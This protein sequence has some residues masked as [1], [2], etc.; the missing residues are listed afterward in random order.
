[1]ASLDGGRTAGGLSSRCKA[2]VASAARG[3]WKRFGRRLRS[4]DAP[5]WLRIS[6]PCQG[7]VLGWASP[8]LPWEESGGDSGCLLPSGSWAGFC[9]CCKRPLSL[10]LDDSGPQA[11]RPRHASQEPERSSTEQ[12]SAG[13]FAYVVCIWGQ[14]P[15]YILGAMVLAHSLRS[16]GTGHDLVALHTNDVPQEAVQLLGRSGWTTTEVEYVEAC[17]NLYQ[18]RCIKGRFADVFTKLRLFSLVEYEKVLLLDA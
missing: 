15:E 3:V 13:K 18:E 1:M 10:V 17:G 4:D 14:N 9:S 5:R 11:K 2:A 12:S 7:S 8:A 16:T 6:S